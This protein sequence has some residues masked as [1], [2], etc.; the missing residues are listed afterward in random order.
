MAGDLDGQRAGAVADVLE[1]HAGD[2]AAVIGS[3]RT[4]AKDS[5]GPSGEAANGE[6]VAQ[7]RR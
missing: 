3:L 2:L 1:E 5:T 4:L 6:R 7:L